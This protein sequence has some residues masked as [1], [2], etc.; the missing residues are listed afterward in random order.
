MQTSSK[1]DKFVALKTF[2]FVL[3]PPLPNSITTITK[4]LINIIVVTAAGER[5]GRQCRPLQL[6]PATLGTSRIKKGSTPIHFSGQYI[7]RGSSLFFLYFLV[8][9]KYAGRESL[10]VSERERKRVKEKQRET[11]KEKEREPENLRNEL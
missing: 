4:I 10:R 8:I 5:P 7:E 1:M 2:N 3:L 9:G 11:E 6:Q